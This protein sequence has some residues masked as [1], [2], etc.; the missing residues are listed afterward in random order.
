MEGENDY[1]FQAYGRLL[2]WLG[3][4]ERANREP[5]GEHHWPVRKDSPTHALPDTLPTSRSP[6]GWIMGGISSVAGWGSASRSRP[7]LTSGYKRFPLPFPFGNRN[8]LVAWSSLT[9]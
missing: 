3:S 8:R 6:H 2:A 9:G 1:C 7:G 5:S 4:R